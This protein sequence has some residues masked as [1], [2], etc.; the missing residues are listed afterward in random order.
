MITGWKRRVIGPQAEAASLHA[1]IGQRP[2]SARIWRLP[3][4]QG[5][6]W[7]VV[8]LDGSELC[9][10]ALQEALAKY[11]APEIWNSRSAIRDLQFRSGRAVYQHWRHQSGA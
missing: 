11:G 5:S 6:K 8:E 4:P 9:V 1:K 2:V 10:K 3:Q 7:A